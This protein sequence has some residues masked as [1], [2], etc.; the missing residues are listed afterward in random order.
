LKECVSRMSIGIR[1]LLLR[2]S[3]LGI[4]TG[5]CATAKHSPRQAAVT[6]AT[7]PALRVAV[8]AS[9]P[10]DPKETMSLDQIE[11]KVT[12][13]PPATQPSTPA[14]LEAIQ[15]YA[16]ARA[17]LVDGQ[18]VE[19]I[20]LLERAAKLDPY[21]FDVQ[22]DL[23]RAYMASSASA[24]P[25]SR[26]LAALEKAASLHPDKLG[27]Q[28]ELGR[29]Y[30]NRNDT[31]KALE[32]LQLARL[33]VGYKSGN[34]P[35]TAAMVDFF[36]GRALRQ[37]G[38][39]AAALS[40]Y[41]SL[42][43]RLAHPSFSP[44]NNPELVYFIRHP[45]ILYTELGELYEKRGSYDESLQ[46]YKLALESDKE[47]TDLAVRI[48]RVS[49]RSGRGDEARAG[50]ELIALRSHGSADSLELLKEIYTAGAGPGAYVQELAKL[51]AKHPTER[52]IFY[53]LLDQL[54]A[55]GR[56]DEAERLLVAAARDGKSD[57]DYTRR[58][59]ALY[60]SRNDIESAMRLLVDSLADRPDSLRDIGP[61]WGELLKPAR[62][63]RLRL[64]TLQQ[65]QVPP[66]EEA[67][68]LFWVS[69]LAEIWNRDALAR[70][71]LQQAAALKPPFP[72]VY[73]WL[74]GE[75]WARPDWDEKQKAE[76]C[77]QLAKTVEDEGDKALAAE[78]RG[79]SLLSAGDATGAAKQFVAA[80]APG[81]HS[82]DLQLMHAR[83]LLA[84]G[85]ESRAEQL[86]W[87]LLSDW[88]QDEDAYQELFSIYLKRRSVDQALST[89]GKWLKAI[90]TSVDAR[91]LE[92]AINA[93]IGGPENL[94]VARS[95]YE[96]VFDE[97]PENRDVLRAMEV[98]FRHHGKL[99][100][101]LARLESERTRN[102]DNRE[103]VE[104]LVSL[105]AGEKRLPEASRV[106]DAARAAVARD[107]DLLYYVAHLYE[108]IDQ[109]QTTEE[110]LQEVVRMDPHHAAASNDL[111][112]TWADE[113]K[114][115]DRAEQLVRVAVEAEPDN[116]SY[117][118][119]MAW[120]EYK[121]GKFNEA[122]GYLDRAI[123]P[124][125]RPDP[126]VLDHLGDTLYRL[127]QPQEAVKQWKRSLKRVEES[128]D[129]RDD[130]KDLRLQLM[131]KLQQQE[132]GRPVDVAPVIETAAGKP[133]QA[134]N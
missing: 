78:L 53:A 93:Q 116:Q 73:R 8:A 62:R 71:T 84:G 97:Q 5:G 117:L 54:Q 115:L 47:S 50:A 39:T 79:R 43:N 108:R 31:I 101:F 18:R 51:H 33:T 100:D 15:L 122:R 80:E 81:N 34:E 63:G 118:D 89:L 128:G 112:Y 65:M 67:A 127:D 9:Q 98:F 21:S 35:D 85:N 74:I 103:A 66:R 131:N 90:P 123:G 3:I 102:P 52:L 24:S 76:Q 111:G 60:Q 17:A 91:L 22:Y 109:K 124:A 86:L 56:A 126:V 68:R 23:A 104:M 83:A 13:P 70:S 113:G 134:K 40:S 42:L 36:L 121:R 61:L 12:L 130:L 26:A 38:Y 29:E 75:Y 96:T 92:A 132:K 105:Y 37:S 45:Q 11:P 95:I 133:A 58:L 88:P 49:L 129:T 4:L 46:A 16:R 55:A 1:K 99:D 30:L 10:V 107:P 32:H 82:P 57:P 94:A 48:V 14:P 119:S 20:D 41:E 125:T 69:R 19:A 64:G 72:P 2:F 28:L 114:N 87:R 106:L 110:L 7:N 6:A 25:N 77:E 27:L 59:F 44:R 120:V